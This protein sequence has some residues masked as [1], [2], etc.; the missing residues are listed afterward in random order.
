MRR[1]LCRTLSLL[2]AAGALLV[3]P[4]ALA[5]APDPVTREHLLT[6]ADYV[7]VYPDMRQPFR[8]TLR[9][10]VFAPRG[11][12]DQAQA[13]RGATRIFGSVSPGVRHRAVSLITQ[14]VVRFRTRA[15][16]RA[17]VQRYRFFSR[18]CVGDVA[19]TDGEGG[20]VLLK[21]RAWDPPRVGQESSGMLICWL[22]GGLADWR[23]VLAVRVGRTVT[24]LD[25]TFTDVRPPRGGV[26]ALG[27]LAVGRLRG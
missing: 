1:T 25:V 16:A 6:V 3:P 24:V 20:D 22:Q 18:H 27:E 19:T 4:P 12:Q 10:P 13:V 17:L 9:A 2:V 14:D 26:V 5:S 15:E 7:S 11:C 21:N 23:R 8:I